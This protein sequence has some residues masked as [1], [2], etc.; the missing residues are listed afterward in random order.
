MTSLE[1]VVLVLNSQ[2]TL[3]TLILIGW[4]I[5]SFIKYLLSACYVPCTVII[6]GDIKKNM[7]Q[8]MILFS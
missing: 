5:D 7:I 8:N 6:F 4:L 1:Y 2:I 3:L